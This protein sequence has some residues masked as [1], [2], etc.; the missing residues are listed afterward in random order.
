MRLVLWLGKKSKRE[1]RKATADNFWFNDY[2]NKRSLQVKINTK[3]SKKLPINFSMPQGSVL[4]P[5]LFNLFLIDLTKTITGCDIIQYAND[6]QF[7]HAGSAAVLPDLIERAEATP[8]LK[9]LIS[10]LMA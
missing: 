2:L 5:I 4:G 3:I 7:I 10:T 6:K 1:T 9:N 8:S